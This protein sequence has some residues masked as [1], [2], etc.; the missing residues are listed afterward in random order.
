MRS[1]PFHK[2][3][4]HMKSLFNLPFNSHESEVIEF[5]KQTLQD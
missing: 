1:H 4:V 2:H 5:N 3:T